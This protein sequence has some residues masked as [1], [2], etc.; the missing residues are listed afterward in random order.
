MKAAK[1]ATPSIPTP[2]IFI[3]P[4]GC[5]IA[6]A[7]VL[8]P[9]LAVPVLDESESLVLVETGFTVVCEPVFV[10]L[11]SAFLVLEGL[12]TV[13]DALLDVSEALVLAAVVVIPAK[14]FAPSSDSA[15]LFAAFLLIILA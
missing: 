14:R 9:E 10:V 4:V 5:A 15:A 11:G 2:A 6:A 1:P 12:S 7:P 13:E 3:T 8:V